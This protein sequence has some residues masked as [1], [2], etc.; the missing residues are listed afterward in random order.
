MRLADWLVGRQNTDGSWDE[1][2][3]TW[4]GTTVFQL[5][6][7]G[8]L[9]DTA[10]SLVPSRRADSYAQA[11]R[12][13]SDWVCEHITFRR[14][15]TNYVASGASG[16]ALAHK[17]FPERRYERRAKGL[18]RLAAGRINRGGSKAIACPLPSLT[19]LPITCRW[20]RPEK[21]EYVASMEVAVA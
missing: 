4:K 13:A 7:L 5:I 19:G 10:G 3:G 2:P 15:S 8:A 1:S 9:L 18:A 14:V 21:G 16:L 11:V 17:L 6:A 20:G 12:K